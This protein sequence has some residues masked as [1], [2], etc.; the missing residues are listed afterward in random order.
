M[1]SNSAQSISS[2]V[3]YK[4]PRSLFRHAHELYTRQQFSLAEDAYT[5]LL[6]NFPEQ[7]N[8]AVFKQRGICRH[9]LGKLSGAVEDFKDAIRCKPDYADAY[10][11]LGNT[12]DQIGHYDE[13][14]TA[15]N[16]SLE[17]YP[18]DVTV[19][20]K[21]GICHDRRQ[22]YPRAVADFTAVIRINPRHINAFT[23][24]G[25][26]YKKMGSYDLAIKDYDT[27]IALN[28]STATAYYNRGSCFKM[29]CDFSSALRDYKI[30]AQLYTA[31]SDKDDCFKQVATVS[32]LM[33]TLTDGKSQ[34]SS[35]S[36]QHTSATTE[37]KESKN[38]VSTTT[39]QVGIEEIKTATLLQT[40]DTKSDSTSHPIDNDESISSGSSSNSP[41]LLQS[42]STQITSPSTLQTSSSTTNPAIT[43]GSTSSGSGY[44]STASS[45]FL[46]GNISSAQAETESKLAAAM[47]NFTNSTS[48]SAIYVATSSNSMTN[49]ASVVSQPLTES[50]IYRSLPGNYTSQPLFGRYIQPIPS[51][52]NEFYH[53]PFSMPSLYP[54]YNFDHDSK[55]STIDNP[56]HILTQKDYE[57]C[58]KQI[59]TQLWNIP[60]CEWKSD[61]VQL[62]IDSMGILFKPVARSFKENEIDGFA[63]LHLSEIT[64]NDVDIKGLTLKRLNMMISLIK[65]IQFY[66]NAISYSRSSTIP[67]FATSNLIQQASCPSITQLQNQLDEEKRRANEASMCILC[68]ERNKCVAFRPCGHVCSCESCSRRVD[69]CPL[70]RA[71]VQQ[72]VRVFI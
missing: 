25:I 36:S 8:A 6:I 7:K 63:M 46:S 71:P 58:L 10:S 17:I 20:N 56:M 42:S 26:S 35:S 24:R 16:K 15:Y 54:I 45:S 53:N 13:A 39:Q 9:R 38:N 43:S 1:T 5:N 32:A 21:R 18:F 70:C 41:T 64:S 4:D 50:Y 72:R 14:I 65:S 55:T 59:P 67:T 57:Q 60:P 68:Y 37:S 62:L 31:Q 2:S 22:D 33:E 34:Q 52:W 27:A 44:S 47:N 28:P 19:L 11:N 66:Q 3:D 48:N 51:S 69:Q 29:K 30:A 40:E 61:H 23:N 12:L 49:R